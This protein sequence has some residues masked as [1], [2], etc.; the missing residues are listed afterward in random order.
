MNGL[1]N[2]VNVNKLQQSSNS[3][4]NLNVNYKN[5]NA[6]LATNQTFKYDVCTDS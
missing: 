5:S 6:S 2:H 1:A 3:S 4:S